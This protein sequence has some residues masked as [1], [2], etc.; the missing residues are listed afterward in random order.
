MMA[1]DRTWSIL[2]PSNQ[3]S[4]QLRN[5]CCVRAR[6]ANIICE[7]ALSTGQVSICDVLTSLSTLD[8]VVYTVVDERTEI[9]C[10]FEHKGMEMGTWLFDDDG[11]GGG[12]FRGRRA[13]PKRRNYRQKRRWDWAM[14]SNE[15]DKFLIRSDRLN[16]T[17]TGSIHFEDGVF[18][19]D[20]TSIHV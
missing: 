2:V 17:G 1:I 16:Q 4:L 11:G 18:A 10:R 15:I 13:R 12:S 7:A 3:H 9:G 20:Q 6:I 5:S 8:N 19:H 14:A